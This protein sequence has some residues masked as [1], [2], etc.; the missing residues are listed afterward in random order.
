VIARARAAGRAHLE[1][2][3]ALE[4]F[5]SYGIPTAPARIARSATESAS[6]GSELGFPVVMKVVSPTSTI[7]VTWAA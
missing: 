2:S 3:E 6:V 1:Q 5:A 7:R 4:L